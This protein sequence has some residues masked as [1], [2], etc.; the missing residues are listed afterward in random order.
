MFRFSCRAWIRSDTLT[1]LIDLARAGSLEATNTAGQRKRIGELLIEAGIIKADEL[2]KG[3]QEAQ[4]RSLR[5][6][7]VL[8]MLQCAT[9][10]DLEAVLQAQTKLE[11]GG[12]SHA[13]AIEALRLASQQ[14]LTFEDALRRQ[15]QNSADK[16]KH[17]ELISQ[18]QGQ[19]QHSE[20]LHGP[21]HREVGNLCAKIGD[22]YA[23]LGMIP[24]AEKHYRR[25]LQIFERSFGQ[26]NLK[27]A[28]CMSKIADLHF[29]QK[30]YSEAETLYWRVLDITQ[31]AWGADHLD[32]AQCHKSLAR[33]L[34]AQGRLKEA[35]QFYLSSLRITEKLAGAES[36]E[37]VD[38][39]RH[40]ASFWSRQGKKPE[41]KRLGDLLVESAMLRPEQLADALQ[42][43]QDK[44]A[45]LGQT[46]VRLNYLKEAELR[47][48]LQAQLL[49]GDGV[50]PSPLAA[51]AL[52][53]CKQGSDFDSALRDLGWEP[54]RFTSEELQILIAT[55]EELM[56]AEIALG[57]EHAGVAVLSTRLADIY[58]AQQKWAE[59]EPLYRRAIAIL[60]K[61]FGA[62]DPEVASALCKLGEL[63][64]GQGKLVEAERTLWRAL[65]IL[66]QHHGQDHADVAECLDR[67]ALLQQK[68]ANPEQALRLLQSS[69]A[70]KEKVLGKE[71][72]SVAVTSERLAYTLMLL[73]RY[74]EAESMYLRLIR[75]KERQSDVNRIEL[76]LLL[77]KLGELYFVQRDYSKTE[78]QYELALEIREQEADNSQALFDLMEKYSILLERTG[79]SEES[80]KMKDR[81]QTLKRV[82]P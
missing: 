74:D 48:A 36:A 73:D 9:S 22:A 3:L 62:K 23:Q 8:V 66:Q 21:K 10:E 51:R 71:H 82:R 2:P 58:A 61:F 79:R 7:E 6:G 26:R 38:T 41:R 13:D 67:I 76:A 29:Q 65:E 20:L 19:L 35:E 81:A 54:D 44:N 68:Q 40:L 50:L 17:A 70:I 63:Q 59:A 39:L 16:A 77:E 11:D 60:E 12:V 34:E 14:R 45:P 57:F 75:S 28:S 49:V 72:P 56:T 52:R 33:L 46:L 78:T 18:L 47:P 55:A 30:K 4:E 42:Q 5:L 32:V 27:V 1:L 64:A 69:R 24:E 25:A 80:R 37:I 15:Q 31:S 43:S 53:M